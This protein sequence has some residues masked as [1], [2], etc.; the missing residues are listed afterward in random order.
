V[1]PFVF[2]VRRILIMR[3]YR[4][5]SSGVELS[6][7]YISASSVNSKLAVLYAYALA[8]DDGVRVKRLLKL[9]IM[10]AAVSVVRKHA[11][12]AEK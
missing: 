10:L 12:V 7:Q 11:V 9:S 1:K 8:G 2:A 3:C 4:L 6:N 5:K